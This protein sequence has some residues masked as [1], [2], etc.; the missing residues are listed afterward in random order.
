MHY[1]ITN[2]NKWKSSP[3]SGDINFEMMLALNNF[4]SENF[5]NKFYRG[6]MFL[7]SH[8]YGKIF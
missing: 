6:E 3:T 4:S 8:S 2:H 7:L 1:G 5:R